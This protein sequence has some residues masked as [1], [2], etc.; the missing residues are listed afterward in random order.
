[1]KLSDAE[2]GALRRLAGEGLSDGELAERFG[3][4][5]RHAGIEVIEPGEESL[6][7]SETAPGRSGAGLMSRGRDSPRARRCSRL[8]ICV[9]IRVRVQ[10][11]GQRPVG[12]TVG[13]GV[14]RA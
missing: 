8:T 2:V 13:E 14:G 1:M 4:S 11:L 5:R 10:A 3:I 12:G 9:P 7:A 6:R